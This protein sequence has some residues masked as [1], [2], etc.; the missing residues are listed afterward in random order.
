MHSVKH[1]FVVAIPTYNRSKEVVAKTLHTLHTG[2]VNASS[3]YLFVANK[4]QH[5][6]YQSTVPSHLYNDIV[7]GKKGIRNQRVFISSYFPNNQCIVS[8]DDDVEDLQRLHGD[9]LVSIKD[10]NTFFRNAFDLLRKERLF[11]WGIYPVHN[12]FFMTHK[13]TTDLRFVIGVTFGYINRR[14]K[15]LYPSIQSESKEDYEQTLLFYRKDGGVVRFN[16]VTAK[17]KFNAPGGLGTDRYERN[18]IAAEYLHTT[19]P[20]LVRRADRKNGTP[21]VRLAKSPR[22]TK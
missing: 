10:I 16:G 18:R 22:L 7:I 14:D 20:D 1:P 3:I 21:E 2:N 19:Y 13:I 15:T 6:L 5:T 9:K 17:T 11:L 8:M 4:Q 12:P